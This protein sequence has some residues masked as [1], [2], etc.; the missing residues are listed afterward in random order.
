ME[1]FL[2]SSDLSTSIAGL[3]SEI[4]QLSFF[5]KPPWSNYFCMKN[6]CSMQLS[7][8]TTSC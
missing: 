5:A 4:L 2:P 8:P 6:Y 3:G 1:I 7:F